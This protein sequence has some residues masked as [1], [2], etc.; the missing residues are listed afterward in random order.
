MSNTLSKSITEIIDSDYK[1]YA[2]YTISNRAIPCYID[3]FKPVHRKILY[4]M[5]KNF[6][7]KKVKVAELGGSLPSI[8]YHHGETSAMGAV[9]TL[10]ADYDNNFPILTQHGAFGTRLIPESAAP[11]YI[12]VTLNDKFY[13]MFEDFDIMQYSKDRDENPEPLTYLPN[14]P[15]VLVNGIKGIAVGF[16]TNILPH[17]PKDI[18]KLCLKYLK[19]K[20]I[21]KDILMPS[22]PDFTGDI[23][24]ESH[25]K[26]KTIGRVT[27]TGKLEYT[28]D[29]LP[30]GYNRKK[31]FDIL[32]SLL[33]AGKIKDF[34]DQCSTGFKFKIKVDSAQDSK[35]SKDP[36]VFFKLEQ[37]L[38]ENY[39][40]LDEYSNLVLFDKKTD[41][42]KKFVDF[43]LVTIKER[44]DFDAKKLTEKLNQD[45]IKAK[46]ISNVINN[47]VDFKNLSKDQLVEYIKTNLTTD[48]SIISN[49]ILIP[50]YAMTSDNVDKLKLSIEE[51]EIKIRALSNLTPESVLES[52]LANIT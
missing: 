25:D 43:R 46:F 28:I 10:A 24:S 51:T 40:T 18:A 44:L 26:F 16:A 11:R 41:I 2:T 27:K 45:N 3:G 5:L 17:K 36:I 19:G 47:K 6:K 12:F 23:I 9:V 31:Y 22:F 52:R 30:I 42:I 37:S 49:L 48:E 4:S 32:C 1:E 35:I 8:G 14:I 20:N 21:D 39:T 13:D 38:T 29:E 34:E 50:L 15:W 33:D 7:G